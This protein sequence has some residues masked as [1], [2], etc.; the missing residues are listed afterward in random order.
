LGVPCTQPVKR[1]Q[2]QSVFCMDPADNGFAASEIVLIAVVWIVPGL[3]GQARYHRI[4]VDIAQ[5][6]QKIPDSCYRLTDKSPLKKRT[7]P[8]V[9]AI[10]KIDIS[11]PQRFHGSFQR[12]NVV[13]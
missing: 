9:L 10:K 3:F 8:L 5:Y 7:Y 4:V 13:F 12:F 6:P 11:N 2:T 1:T